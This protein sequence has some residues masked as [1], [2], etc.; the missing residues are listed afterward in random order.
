[1]CPFHLHFKNWNRREDVWC[2]SVGQESVNGDQTKVHS[3]KFVMKQRW[4]LPNL[5]SGTVPEADSSLLCRV[6]QNSRGNLGDGCG[7]VS[8]GAADPP[9]GVRKG[10]VHLQQGLPKGFGQPLVVVSLVEPYAIDVLG[11]LDDVVHTR[12]TPG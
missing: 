2:T 6:L 7:C 9:R 1:M 4:W 5:R 12:H 8:A 11:Y 3:Q 10:L